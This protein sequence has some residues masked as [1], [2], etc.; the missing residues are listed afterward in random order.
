MP[1]HPNLDIN[2][3]VELKLD[4]GQ[5]VAGI[6]SSRVEDMGDGFIAV[7]APSSGG[8][9]IA[10]RQGDEIEILVPDPSGFFS[11]KCKVLERRSEPLP[12][13]LLERP[14]EYIRVQLRE[15]V[16]V[17]A[18]LEVV[19]RPL[20]PENGSVSPGGSADVPAA[21][22]VTRDVSGGGLRISFPV[23]CAEVLARCR[24]VGL[25][26]LLKLGDGSAPVAAKARVV[27]VEVI[28]DGSGSGQ[29]GDRLDIAVAFT[30]I[31]HRDQDRIV[32]F[33]F[34]RQREM[35]RKGIL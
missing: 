30:E 32:K 15:H 33:V 12:V 4:G 31:S 24:E 6:Y 16:R 8:G 19:V 26:V 28:R 29:D 7:S 18:S 35:I 22:G 21:L 27:R 2:V 13:L 25:A 20:A 9:L 34:D 3:R 14:R 17:P 11:A 5:G 10:V 23:E 1:R